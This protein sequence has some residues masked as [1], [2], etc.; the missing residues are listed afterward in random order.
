MLPHLRSQPQQWL[1]L[2]PLYLDLV[3]AGK[4]LRRNPLFPAQQGHVNLSRIPVTMD[5]PYFAG[6]LN[7]ISNAGGCFLLRSGMTIEPYASRSFLPV[8]V[9]TAHL[10]DLQRI[11]ELDAS[12]ILTPAHLAGQ[13]PCQANRLT[14]EP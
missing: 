14:G 6:S 10:Q 4:D 3:L 7:E 8:T 13:A 5:E 1:G 2:L 12:F 11:T 9:Y